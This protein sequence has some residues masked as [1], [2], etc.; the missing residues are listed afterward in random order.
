MG[1]R[2]GAPPRRGALRPGTRAGARP[3]RL[4]RGAPR[5]GATRGRRLEGRGSSRRAGAAEA[6]RAADGAHGRAASGSRISTGPSGSS[7]RGRSS[8]RAPPQGK[9]WRAR[10]A[11]WRA[12]GGGASCPAAWSLASVREK[13]KRP[14]E[15]AS[16]YAALSRMTEGRNPPAEFAQRLAAVRSKAGAIDGAD[17][18][19]KL[20]TIT[21]ARS[22][23]GGFHQRSGGARRG[24]WKHR[25]CAESLA[26]EP[27][28]FRSDASPADRG[29]GFRSA[30]GR[31]RGQ[32]RATRNSR[33]Q[34][35]FDL[36]GR[37][38]HSGLRNQL[39]LAVCFDGGR[40]T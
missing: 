28:R 30:S 7:R 19:M 34:P 8:E 21:A 2:D 4:A 12:P 9:T 17:V 6:V 18:L 25:R 16:L 36:L 13:Q 11:T 37:L 23:D 33:L 5:A 39:P 38:R 29:H 20:R 24:R 32:D 31:A 14:D 22:G 1:A 10:G 3:P 35:D 27:G 15:A 40:E 26:E